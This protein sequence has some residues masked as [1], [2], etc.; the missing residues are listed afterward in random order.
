[1]TRLLLGAPRR[2]HVGLPLG[3]AAQAGGAGAAAAGE[4]GTGTG[5]GR[6]RRAAP[7]SHSP[8]P[9]C[10][11]QA[12]ASLEGDPKHSPGT[13]VTPSPP[14]GEGN[15]AGKG[16]RGAGGALRQSGSRR[17][18][19][20]H[21][22]SGVPLLPLPVSPSTHHQRQAARPL[23]GKGPGTQ[24]S[25]GERALISWCDSSWALFVVLLLSLLA[26]FQ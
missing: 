11:F 17:L 3:G 22:A 18:R 13:G 1:M 20:L 6:R 12:M 23:H 14:P 16:V 26:W 15:G 5:T 19:S 9:P 24:R 2:R 7:G 4:T 10:C 25:P 8:P 21:R